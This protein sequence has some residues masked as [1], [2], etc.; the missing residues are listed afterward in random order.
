MRHGRAWLYDGWASFPPCAAA[1]GAMT[2]GRGHLREDAKYVL[3]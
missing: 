3:V 2:P 1:P